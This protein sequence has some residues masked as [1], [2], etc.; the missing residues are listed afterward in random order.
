MADT[1][2]SRWL[3]FYEVVS[4]IPC[5]RVATYGQVARIAGFPQ[6]ARQ[7]GYALAALPE[8]RAD[9]PW[10]RVINSRGEV[11]PRARSGMHHFQQDLLESE[12]VT[13]V[14]GRVDLRRFL[15]QGDD[16]GAGGG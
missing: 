15:W 14:G 9:I 13:F 1:S 10:Q 7:V 3:T 5:G 6:H 16:P 11:S 8:S 4:R 12:G 2:G